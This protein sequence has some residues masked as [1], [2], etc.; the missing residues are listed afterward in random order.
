MTFVQYVG[1]KGP[2][3]NDCGVCER[4]ELRID[5]TTANNDVSGPTPQGNLKGLDQ[6]PSL[7]LIEWTVTREPE[8]RSWLD[9]I[10]LQFGT[11]SRSPEIH[12]TSPIVPGLSLDLPSANDQQP[13]GSRMT[14]SSPYQDHRRWDSLSLS[15]MVPA[16]TFLVQVSLEPNAWD[17]QPFLRTPPRIQRWPTF[18]CFVGERESVKDVAILHGDK[19]W[20]CVSWQRQGYPIKR[21]F[22][23]CLIVDCTA[24]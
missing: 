11:I 7:L 13:G 10:R 4:G 22:V 24:C 16:K 2:P 18:R 20:N 23:V 3:L 12:W 9:E 5:Q 6:G 8:E 14:L 17:Q 15:G 1:Q 21:C 19:I